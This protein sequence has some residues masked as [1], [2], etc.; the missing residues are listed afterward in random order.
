MSNLVADLRVEKG[1]GAGEGVRR[2]VETI[3]FPQ[4]Y[5]E[6]KMPLNNKI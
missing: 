2:Y 5:C 4:F 1:M 6:P 3:L